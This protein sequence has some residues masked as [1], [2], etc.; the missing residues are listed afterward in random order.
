[1]EYHAGGGHPSMLAAVAEA[2]YALGWERN[3]NTVKLACFAP[4]IQNRNVWRHTPYLALFDADLAKTV[5]SAS[6]WQEWLFNRYRGT[7]TVEVTVGDQNSNFGPLY[8]VASID[9]EKGEVYLK[10]ANAGEAYQPLK[11]R[12]DVGANAVNGTTLHAAMPSDNDAHNDVDEEKVVPRAMEDLGKTEHGRFTWTVPPWSIN[13]LQF[14][15]KMKHWEEDQ[16]AF[17]AH[18]HVDQEIIL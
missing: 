5:L 15:F 18:L 1:M 16:R 8:W 14:D 12:L 2:V 7:E 13:V 3:P 9:E 17:A 11:V 10:F 4:L 6:Y